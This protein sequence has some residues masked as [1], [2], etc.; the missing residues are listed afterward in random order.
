MSVPTTVAQD[1]VSFQLKAFGSNRTVVIFSGA[2]AGELGAVLDP[3]GTSIRISS[4]GTSFSANSE[5]PQKGLVSFIQQVPRG[6]YDDLVITLKQTSTLTESR[7]DGILKLYISAVEARP[8][9]TSESKAAAEA[10]APAAEAPTTQKA[11]ASA[12]NL[13]VRFF[14]KGVPTDQNQV[15]IA[16]PAINT[17]ES[18]A[19]VA[20]L[21]GVAYFAGLMSGWLTEREFTVDRPIEGA[22]DESESL[23]ESLTAEVVDLRKQLSR[24][25]Q[26]LNKLDSAANAMDVK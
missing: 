3:L 13:P 16:L 10:A 20:T 7:S 25:Q 5:I 21:R 26:R 2:S 4:A 23:I 19:F 1:T 24:A 9:N 8:K 14:T 11:V 17:D 12:V 15:I 22:S 18:P 6:G